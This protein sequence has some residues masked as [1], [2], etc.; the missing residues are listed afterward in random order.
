MPAGGLWCGRLSQVGQS[1]WFSFPVRGNRIFT[2]VTQAL[3]ETSA[4][5]ESKALPSI[6]VWDAFDPVGATAVGAAPGLNGD[7]TGETWLRV[8]TNGDDMVR[9]GIAD[10]RGDGRPDYAY[11]GWVLYADTVSP[12]RLPA[13]GGSITIQGMGFRLADTVTVGGQA[14]TLTS[15]S[16][17]QITAVVPPAPAGVTGSVDLEVDDEP[18][19]Y[20]AAVIPGGVSYDSGNGDALNLNAAPAN[21]V[22][23]GEPL[24]FSVTALGS[25]LTPAGG[26]TV[27]YTVTSGAATLACGLPVCSVVATGDGRATMNVTAM[28]TTWSTVTAALTNGS[29]LEAQFVGGTPAVLSVL[30]R[31][32]SL[33]A[34]ATITW[35]VQALV[36]NNGVPSS[37]QSVAWQAV[38][39]SGIT[40]QGPVSVTTN[41]SGIAAQTLTVGPLAEG[42]T[43]SI[44]AC[45][46]GT[47]QCVAFT[48]FGARPEYAAL[49]AISGT[50]QSLT[51]SDT[52]NQIV[53][54]L[55][56]MDG[57]PMAGGTVAL[58]EALYAW[59]P[60]C[61]PN[62]VCPPGALLATQASMGTTA[63]D[64]SVTFVPAS[65]PGVATN[66]MGLAASGNTSTVNVSIEQHP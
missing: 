36:E 22:P 42:Q 65:L 3:D 18:A 59:T 51:A 50:S 4:P 45:L 10:L 62:V 23:I 35:T 57:N 16:P 14:A 7:A 31:Q 37:G 64:G 20:A 32:L 40:L 26:V 27:I 12:T 63:V 8:A 28:S 53:L 11:N 61:S 58:Y 55:L 34:G 46:N 19:L 30:T 24:P 41:S 48:A 43:A 13:S 49:E 9:I 6:G 66:L 2:V 47:S 1:D 15:I 25:N 60:P 52:P 39:S 5:T 44:N 21:T 38:A 17:N 29:S 54:R 56:D 33:A